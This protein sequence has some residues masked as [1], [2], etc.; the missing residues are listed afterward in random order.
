MARATVTDTFAFQNGDTAVFLNMESG[1]FSSGDS[2]SVRRGNEIVGQSIIYPKDGST[3]RA[4]DAGS[5]PH[6]LIKR[7]SC[8]AGDLVESVST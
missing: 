1:K 6:A 4:T 7:I 2:I 3:Q 8:I 5:Q